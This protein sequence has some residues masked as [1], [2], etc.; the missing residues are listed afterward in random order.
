MRITTLIACLPLAATLVACQPSG[1]Y[2]NQGNYH[3]SSKGY[4]GENARRTNAAN[5][6]NGAPFNFDRAGYY[7]YQGNYAGRHA[8]SGVADDFY[9]PRGMCRIYTPDRTMDTQLPPE[10]CRSHYHLPVDAFVVYGG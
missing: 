3:S 5:D 4:Q 7:D 2:D 1:F 9:P 8:A 10:Q 6:R